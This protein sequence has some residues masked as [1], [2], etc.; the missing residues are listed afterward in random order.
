MLA[1]DDFTEQRRV[2]GS[3]LFTFSDGDHNRVIVVRRV[4]VVHDN[5]TEKETFKLQRDS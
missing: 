2:I 1:T 3:L 5:E 4:V